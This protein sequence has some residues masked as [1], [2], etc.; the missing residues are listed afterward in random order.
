MPKAASPKGLRVAYL[1]GAFPDALEQ[2]APKGGG[3][4]CRVLY[5]M[6]GAVLMRA[7]GA[8]AQAV[9]GTLVFFPPGSERRHRTF[10]NRGS[11]VDEHRHAKCRRMDPQRNRAAPT[12]RR[13]LLACA[14]G[15]RAASALGKP[16]SVSRVRRRLERCAARRVAGCAPRHVGHPGKRRGNRGCGPAIRLRTSPAKIFH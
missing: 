7:H 1:N 3:R 9:G 15:S 4:V 13:M 6:R 11:Q 12:R 2:S 8:V 16:L 14:L 5:V 10:G